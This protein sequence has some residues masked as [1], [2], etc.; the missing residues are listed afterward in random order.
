[1]SRPKGKLPY[2][3]D[4]SYID[5]EQ[6][7]TFRKEKFLA[8]ARRLLK[9]IG[10]YLEESGGVLL[11]ITTCKG[12]DWDNGELFAVY[13]LSEDRCISLCIDGD[14]MPL[15]S[16]EIDGVNAFARAGK[17]V[18]L[19]AKRKNDP[20]FQV[21]EEGMTVWLDPGRNA[22]VLAERLRKIANGKGYIVRSLMMDSRGFMDLSQGFGIDATIVKPGQ[23]FIPASE[24]HPNQL[25]LI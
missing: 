4:P 11:G 16:R 15:W 18:R 17:F 10:A 21:V 2:V 19:E 8:D 22:L 14:P 5:T 3:L 25:T 13:G 24:Q 7:W 12:G 6:G 20:T 1:M 9:D 23:D